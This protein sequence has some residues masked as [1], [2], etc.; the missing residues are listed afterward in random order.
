MYL[1]LEQTFRN[2]P[3]NEHRTILNWISKLNYWTKQNDT[4]G[5]AAPGTGEWLL[6][7]SEFKGWIEGDKRV[8]WCPGDRNNSLFLS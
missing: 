1:E 2:Q 4:F 7:S 3:E 5:H 6:E 8:L